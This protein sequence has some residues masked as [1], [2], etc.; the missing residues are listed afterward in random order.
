L[1]VVALHGLAPAA[2]ESHRMV[3]GLVGFPSY[4]SVKL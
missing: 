2:K 1:N 4:F 3:A